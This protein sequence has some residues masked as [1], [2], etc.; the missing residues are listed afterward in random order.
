MGTHPIFESDFDCLTEMNSKSTIDVPRDELDRILGEFRKGKNSNFGLSEIFGQ[1][2]EVC[3]M[4]TALHQAHYD[5]D[6]NNPNSTQLKNDLAEIPAV[7]EIFIKMKALSEKIQNLPVN[8][9]K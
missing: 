4:Q 8:A 5:I 9:D 2:D 1:L 7:N 6:K 3:E